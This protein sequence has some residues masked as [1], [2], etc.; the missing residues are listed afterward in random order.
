MFYGCVKHFSN[1]AFYIS[2]VPD[3]SPFKIA[4]IY[5]SGEI[6]IAIAVLLVVKKY[7]VIGALSLLVLM[8]SFLPIH[9]WDVFSDTPA[10]G[11]H[12]LALIRLPIELLFISIAWKLKRIYFN[13]KYYGITSKKY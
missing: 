6:E 11:S 1:S 7:R 8:L 2:F 9:V 4:I 5:F 10:I 13:K 3:L 12:Q